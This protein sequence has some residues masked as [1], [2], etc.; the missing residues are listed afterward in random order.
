M[1]KKQAYRQSSQ[2]SVDMI[3]N[4]PEDVMSSI[5][6]LVPIRDAVRTSIFVK[7]MEVQVGYHP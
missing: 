5:L 2:G 1:K 7:R 3:S 4:L 6:A